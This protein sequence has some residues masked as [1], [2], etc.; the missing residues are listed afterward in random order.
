[1]GQTPTDKPIMRFLRMASIVVLAVAATGC[2]GLE[3]LF[4]KSPTSA[5]DSSNSARSYLGTW[6]GPTAIAP[7]AQSCT[8]LQWKITSQTGTQI[9]GDFTA[10]CAGGINLVGTL[11][12][13]ITDTTTIP[14]A[15]S[16]NATQGAT[17]CTFNLS[18]T[19]TFQGTSNIVVNYSGTACGVAVSGSETIKRP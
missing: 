16:G 12:A 4:D 17:N 1:M 8:G 15:A 7:G 19:G 13:T 9:T 11:V 2:Y 3:K 10:T 18:G 6:D 5:S 14:W